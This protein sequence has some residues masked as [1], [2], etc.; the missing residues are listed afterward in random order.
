MGFL[1]PIIKISI[2]KY[3]DLKFFVGKFELSFIKRKI[4]YFS[5]IIPKI[6]LK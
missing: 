6:K 3:I 2:N 4:E 1:V 5:Q